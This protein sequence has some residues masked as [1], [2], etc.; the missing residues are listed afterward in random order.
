MNPVGV[1][2]TLSLHWEASVPV[3]RKMLFLNLFFWNLILLIFLHS[4][5]NLSVSYLQFLQDTLDALF[6]IM[7]EMSDDETYDFLVFDALVSNY[8]C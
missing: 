4:S 8:A 2:I 6:N 5:D 1:N 7:M 3:F